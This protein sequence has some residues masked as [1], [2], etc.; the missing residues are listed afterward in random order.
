MNSEGRTEA[1]A[2]H[3]DQKLQTNNLPERRFPQTKS[4]Q[5][6]NVAN[7]PTNAHNQSTH[8]ISV[9][10]DLYPYC[11][12][13]LRKKVKIWIFQGPSL[14]FSGKSP[15]NTQNNCKLKHVI[16]KGSQ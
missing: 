2:I 1:N 8:N 9:Q 12:T 14:K 16:L 6:L 10:T 4:N 3:R 5:W 7:I 15:T 11:T 13:L